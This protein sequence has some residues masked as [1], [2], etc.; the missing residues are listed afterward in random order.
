MDYGVDCSSFVA[1]IYRCFGFIFPRNTSNQSQSLKEKIDLSNKSMIDKLKLIKDK[2]PSLLYQKG[3]VMLYIGIYNGKNYIIH[4]SGSSLKV[5]L[6][7]L[8][9]SNYL[10][11]INSAITIK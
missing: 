6:T 11:K 3:H 7:V 2:A 8:D 4:A 5:S 1:N 9:N 10:K